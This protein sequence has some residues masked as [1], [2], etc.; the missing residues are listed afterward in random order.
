[1]CTTPLSRGL[2]L[3]QTVSTL[4]QVPPSR[5]QA[6][7]KDSGG[8]CDKVCRQLSLTAKRV[9]D[10]ASGRFFRTKLKRAVLQS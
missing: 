1:M 5:N 4:S 9:S 6:Q 10:C 8:T 7:I 3:S 2:H